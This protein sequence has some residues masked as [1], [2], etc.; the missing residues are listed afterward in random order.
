MTKQN[1]PKAGSGSSAR[2][3]ADAGDGKPTV[4]CCGKRTKEPCPKADSC[5]C[6][7]HLEMEYGF[8]R[9]GL[10]VFDR[11]QDCCEVYNFQED[12]GA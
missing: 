8:C 2:L 10:G 4:I 12:S 3:G 5:T 7:G 11:C 6:G 1:A 9:Y